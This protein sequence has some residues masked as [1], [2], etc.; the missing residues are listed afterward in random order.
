MAALGLSGGDRLMAAL[1]AINANL[2][3]AGPDGSV[4]V[5]FLENATPE[6]GGMPTAANAALQEFGGTIQRQAGSATVFRKVN[7]AG[8]GFTRNGRFVKRSASNFST[9]H[10]TPAYTITIPPRPFFRTMIKQNAGH[11]GDDVGKLLKQTDFNAEKT[12]K[13]MGE[14]I[15][16]ELRQSI[17]DLTS[18]PL[19][20]STIRKKSKGKVS[21]LARAIG[22]PAKPLIDTG[23]MFNSVDYETST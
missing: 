13:K 7:A 10:A 3:S 4:R 12:L 18:P 11:W 21:A 15:A 8:T 5:G 17:R 19:A 6:P 23:H 16:G 14:Q 9:T 2:T 22:G 1:N 20:D